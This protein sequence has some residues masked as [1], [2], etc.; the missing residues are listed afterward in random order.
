M[1]SEGSGEAEVFAGQMVDDTQLT[2]D[3][4][5]DCVVTEVQADID[6]KQTFDSVDIT[7]ASGGIADG[8][9]LVE[10]GTARTVVTGS[11]SGDEITVDGAKLDEDTQK[12]LIVDGSGD[13]VVNNIG[14]GVTV[15]ADGDASDAG[16]AVSGTVGGDTEA[17][18]VNG[19]SLTRLSL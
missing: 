12:S 2:L 8:E 18:V 7:T 3:G 6:A 13:F 17:R 15:D 19:G 4:S 9:L 1:N 14:D 10:A 11:A 16:G 5:S